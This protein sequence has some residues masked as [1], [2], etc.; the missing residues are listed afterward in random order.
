MYTDRSER[1]LQDFPAL[2]PIDIALYKDCTRKKQIRELKKLAGSLENKR[3]THVSSTFAGGG[4]AEMLR[5]I[6]P[7]AKGFGVDCEW[8]CIEGQ[9]DFFSITKRLHNVIQGLKQEFSLDD[10]LKTYIE[11]NRNNFQNTSVH[12]DLT[13]VHDPQPC[14]SIVHGEYEGKI[15]WRCHI[16]TTDA[17]QRIWNFLL[18]YINGYDGAIFSHKNFVK[19]G[20]KI[21]VYKITPAI[22]PLTVKNKHRTRNEA[23]ST[24]NDLFREHDI[25]PERPIVLAVSRYDIHKNQATII[26]SFKKLKEDSEIQHLKPI[27]L[28]VGNSATDDPEGMTM[29]KQISKLAEE[30]PDIY[31]LLNIPNNDESIGALMKLADVFVHI[32]TKEGFGLVVTEA[33]WQGTPVIG[34]KVGGIVQQIRN[35]KT[36]FLVEPFE[37]NDVATYM[38]YI[39]TEHSEREKMGYY[40]IETVRDKFLITSQITKYFILM[41][42]MLG[43][44]FPYFAI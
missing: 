40:A 44:D 37:H 38:K 25:D 14:A 15:L 6:I 2:N 39:L 7:I 20:L 43:I 26:E 9:N 30:D 34:S 8:Y 3:W 36:G 10:L 23:L 11:A 5:S 28:I 42:Y 13:I 32:S 12:S 24:L 17:D 41:R 22:D 4:I 19:E 1:Y 27:L 16:D 35:G 18:P 21:P 33:L 31:T 29:Y